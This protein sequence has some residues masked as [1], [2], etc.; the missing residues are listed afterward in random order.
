MDFFRR[1]FGSSGSNRVYDDNYHHDHDDGIDRTFEQPNED[2]RTRGFQVFSDPLQMHQYFEHQMNE[3]LKVFGFH[4]FDNAEFNNIP[5]IEEGK[6][7]EEHSGDLRDQFLK[8][9]YEYP[10]KTN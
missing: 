4:G 6:H 10:K 7:S 1:F 9:G 3:I 5:I 8:R 2:I